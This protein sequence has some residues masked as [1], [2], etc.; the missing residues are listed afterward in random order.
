MQGF[1][2]GQ[3]VMSFDEANL[4]APVYEDPAQSAI[5]DDVGYAPTPLGPDGERKAAAWVWSMSMNANSQDKEAA[6]LFLQWLTSKETMI[7]THL[8]GNMNPVRA[9]RL[10]RSAGRRAR[11]ELGTK[12]RDNTGR[13]PRRWRR[14][15]PCVSL[16]I[17]S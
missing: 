17:R 15:P 6:W 10:G 12:L 8:G 1:A 14:W 13:S 11:G 5:A 4:F 16:R 3:Y 7:K 9:V 2:S